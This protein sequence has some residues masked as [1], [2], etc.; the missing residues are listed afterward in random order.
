MRPWRPTPRCTCFDG[1]GWD[2]IAFH[3]RGL[4]L[5]RWL[6]EEVRDAYHVIYYKP[7]EDPNHCIDQ[8]TEILADGT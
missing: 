3:A 5:S 6:K 2:W 1:D 8:C 7:C 4:Q